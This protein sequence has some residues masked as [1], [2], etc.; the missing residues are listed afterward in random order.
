MGKMQ[1]IICQNIILVDSNLIPNCPPNT[2]W[3]QST[4][5]LAFGSSE[6]PSESFIKP[7]LWLSKFSSACISKLLQTPPS[8]YNQRLLN[9]IVT[10]TTQLL[11]S[12]F[13]VRHLFIAVMKIPYNLEEV[14]YLG[15]GF[16]S[17]VHGG[18]QLL[19]I[20]VRRAWWRSTAYL[21]VAGKQRRGKC[22]GKMNSS[23]ACSQWSISSSYDPSTVTTQVFHSNYNGLIT[24]LINNFT[25]LLLY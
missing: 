5:P 21:M 8:N 6:L 3:A 7:Y 11:I 19:W 20:H 17:P 13:C 22:S 9:Y 24:V 15:S 14:V 12:N 16:R 18:S 4:I 25:W 23:R 10:A 2:S 1:K